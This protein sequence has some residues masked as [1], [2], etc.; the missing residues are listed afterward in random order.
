M[1]TDLI[2]VG[3]AQLEGIHYP[4]LGDRFAVRLPRTDVVPFYEDNWQFITGTG[5]TA[6]LKS[7]SI[8]EGYFKRLTAS[9]RIACL[10]EASADLKTDLMMLTQQSKVQYAAP[11]RFDDSV[12]RVDPIEHLKLQGFFDQGA[13]Q[14]SRVDCITGYLHLVMTP[15]KLVRDEYVPSIQARVP[16]FYVKD[17]LIAYGLYKVVCSNGMMDTVS[18]SEMKMSFVGDPGEYGI[19]DFVYNMVK[20]LDTR[21]DRYLA[22]ID[23]LKNHRISMSSVRA[24]VEEPLFKKALPGAPIPQ[25]KKHISLLLSSS[26]VPPQSPPKLASMYDLMD[27]LTFYAA[28]LG[29]NTDKQ[30]KAEKSIFQYFSSL[31]GY[32]TEISHQPVQEASWAH[33]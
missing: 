29:E 23:C 1:N 11:A 5:L 2:S 21:S 4:S 20:T 30:R 17:F 19:S 26:P 14:V 16:L 25:L 22:W 8:P 9:T 24:F 18:Q 13:V 3:S 6:F 10:A 28:R 27:T 7:L 15:V 32:D 12:Y 33:A 31:G